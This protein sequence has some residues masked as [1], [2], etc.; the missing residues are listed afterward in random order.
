MV[1]FYPV[2][3]TAIPPIVPGHT[4]G[5]DAF[6]GALPAIAFHCSDSSGESLSM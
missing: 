2:R 6:Q 4:A 3:R 1:Q 5:E